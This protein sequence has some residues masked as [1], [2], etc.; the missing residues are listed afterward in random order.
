MT[1]SEFWLSLDVVFG[2]T[3]GRSLVSDLVLP[4]LG[5][6]ATDALEKEYDPFT[7]WS[8]LIAETGSGEEA[9]WTY[10]RL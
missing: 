7:I 3:L 10:R 5:M 6:T 2:S 4:E 8:A 9:L 1:V